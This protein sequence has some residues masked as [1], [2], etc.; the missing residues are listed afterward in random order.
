MAERVMPNLPTYEDAIAE[1]KEW[2]AYE[3]ETNT[4]VF[5]TSTEWRKRALGR[6]DELYAMDAAC[7]ALLALHR[8]EGEIM[9]KHKHA[10]IQLKAFYTASY[11]SAAKVYQSTGS[12]YH[13]GFMNAIDMC[14]DVLSSA[15]KM[16]DKEESNHAE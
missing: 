14:L 11:G 1:F 6:L 9:D 15:I 13:R 5:K 3:I 10:M 2:I 4:H 8:L 7:N 12:D 16:A